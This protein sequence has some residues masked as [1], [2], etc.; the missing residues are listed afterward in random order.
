MRRF[1]RLTNGFSKR[2]GNHMFAIALYCI[3]YNFVR[4]HKILATPYPRTWAIE[5]GIGDHIWTVDEIVQ[6]LT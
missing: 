1:T 2:V 3:H 4:T 6:I 5:V